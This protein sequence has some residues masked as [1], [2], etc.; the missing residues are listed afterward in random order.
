MTE[1]T[2]ALA[3]SKV[4][5][6]LV[7]PDLRVPCWY[8]GVGETAYVVTGEDEQPIPPLPA[9][10]RIML[11]DKET[12]AAVGP[13]PARAERVWPDSD[14]WGPAT[15][16]LLATRQSTPAGDRAAFWAE[17]GVVWA[18]RVT[19]Q[20]SAPLRS[21][22]T[23]RAPRSTR[24]RAEGLPEHHADPEEPEPTTPD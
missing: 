23:S 15:A 2:T 8:A 20:G 10:L 18:I 7:P 19:P 3:K 9:E 11:R 4:A 24:P 17:H 12:R 6:L 5:W 13:V 21:P 16:A 14:E 22:D 1:V